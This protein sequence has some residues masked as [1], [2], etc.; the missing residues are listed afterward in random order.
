MWVC[1]CVVL[2]LQI[3]VGFVVKGIYLSSIR[4]SHAPYEYNKCVAWYW[5]RLFLGGF[6]YVI[7][8]LIISFNAVA[9]AAVVA[10]VVL[11]Q[12]EWNKSATVDDS[13][14]STVYTRT[15]TYTHSAPVGSAAVILS[16]DLNV[17]DTQRVDSI[18]RLM[19]S[20]V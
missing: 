12:I 11:E 1:Y 10:A 6:G 4:A 19:T 9:V 8:L 16:G 2:L 3:E 17:K 15:H 7:C 20:R 5:L 13:N 18:A 14:C